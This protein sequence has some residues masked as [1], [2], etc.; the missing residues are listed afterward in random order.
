LRQRGALQSQPR[1]AA[2]RRAV[3]TT[4]LQGVAGRR[5]RRRQDGRQRR[6]SASDTTRHHNLCNLDT[7]RSVVVI[8]ADD[9]PDRHPPARRGDTQE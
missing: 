6:R 2:P 7:A 5:R 1:R 4:D 3:Y 8:A 9:L